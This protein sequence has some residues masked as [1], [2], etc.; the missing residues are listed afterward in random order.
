MQDITTTINVILAFFGGLVCISGG[1]S[2]IIKILNPFKK[3]QNKVEEHEKK[4]QS[5]FRKFEDIN[6]AIIE[7][8]KTNKVICKSLLVIMNHEVTGNGVDKLKEQRDTLEQ[9][10]I[11]K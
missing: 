1:V 3:L 2:V 8:E 9:Y 11:D 5:D 6:D 4:L 10:L 7:I